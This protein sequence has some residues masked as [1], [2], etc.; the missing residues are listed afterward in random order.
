MTKYIVP[1][2]LLAGIF[3]SAQKSEN[4]KLGLFSSIE[5]NVGFDLASIIRDKN[6]KTDYERSQLP[7]GKFNYG[8]SGQVGFQPW[9]RFALS[10]GIRYSYI[11]PNYHLLY[12]TA[13]PSFFLGDP[14]D[15]EFT[16][17]FANA[18]MKINQT[19]ATNAG[20]VGLGIGK[21]IPAANRLGNKFQLYLENQVLDGNS[22]VFVGFSYGLI[23]FSNKT[24]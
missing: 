13:Q 10:S 3:V 1:F 17:I 12:L 14:K 5:A 11:D 18:S 22:S 4:H 23:F 8:F 9:N 15:E 24:L 2:L 19:A 16:Y 21:V 20:F 7:P 6:A